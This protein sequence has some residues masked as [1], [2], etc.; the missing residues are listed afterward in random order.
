MAIFTIY[1]DY[2]GGTYIAQYKAPSVRKAALKW[3]E[4]INI[5][6]W[7]GIGKKSNK[8]SLKR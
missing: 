1:V 2:D 5:D 6:E 4:N 7:Y 8:S 3:A